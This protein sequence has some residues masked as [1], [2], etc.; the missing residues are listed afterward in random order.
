MELEMHTV[1][2]LKKGYVGDNIIDL[3]ILSF[4]ERLS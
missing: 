2:S 1:E 3:A 4:I